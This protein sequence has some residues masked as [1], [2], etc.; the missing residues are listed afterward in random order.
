MVE[1]VDGFPGCWV[2]SW[3]EWSPCSHGCLKEGVDAYQWRIRW[4]GKIEPGATCPPIYERR[5][6]QDVRPCMVQDCEMTPWSDWGRC[7]M[8]GT[9][10]CGAG[11]TFRH[12]SVVTYPSESGKPCGP[13]IQFA[14]CHMLRDNCSDPTTCQLFPWTHW[15]DPFDETKS[16]SKPCGTG[17]QIR[18][19][20]TR[21]PC[22]ATVS[23]YEERECNTHPCGTDCRL[24]TS[25]TKVGAC[26]QPCGPLGVQR[27]VRHIVTHGSGDGI[28][29]PPEAARTIFTACN[30]TV[31]CP[32]TEPTETETAPTEAPTDTTIPTDTPTNAPTDT[33]TNAPTD[34]PTDASTDSPTSIPTDTQ[35]PTTTTTTTTEVTQHTETVPITD[36]PQ[37]APP[38]SSSTLPDWF[39]SSTTERIVWGGGVAAAIGVIFLVLSWM[40]SSPARK[41][42]PRLLALAR[43]HNIPVPTG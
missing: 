7:T 15:Y 9:I 20:E 25:Y 33:P 26:S 21:G 6:C 3:S 11:T 2:S 10:N 27:W 35:P 22:T 24:A 36:A 1:Q 38:A 12:R 13:Q 19:R 23:T 43:S 31:V 18:K 30:R 5:V 32:E 28:P 40:M 34:T 37:A 4:V 14:Q 42:N 17:E 41:L 29:C 16:C 39:P 8:G